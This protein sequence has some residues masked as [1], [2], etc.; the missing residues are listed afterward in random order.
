MGQK[1]VGGKTRAVNEGKLTLCS[2]PGIIGQLSIANINIYRGEGQQ[3]G[4]QIHR[5]IDRQTDD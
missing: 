2:K 1:L 4:T 3:A 5:Q